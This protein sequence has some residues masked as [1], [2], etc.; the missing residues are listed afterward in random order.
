MQNLCKTL[1]EPGRRRNMVPGAPR[2]RGSPGENPY[3][4]SFQDSGGLGLA[5]R[6]W[7]LG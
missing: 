1:E 7:Q 4:R 6:Q 2:Q 3:L 5:P